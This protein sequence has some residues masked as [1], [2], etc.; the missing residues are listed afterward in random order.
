M[1]IESDSVLDLSPEAKKA[2]FSTRA[3][4][5]PGSGGDLHLLDIFEKSDEID[6][7]IHADYLFNIENLK[8]PRHQI[9][10][11]QE[12]NFEQLCVV[13]D[14]DMFH[15]SGE[16][17]QKFTD[18]QS[19]ERGTSKWIVFEGTRRRRLGLLHVFGEAVWVFH[20]VWAKKQCTPHAILLQDH[21][22]G[23]GWARLGGDES[24]LYQVAENTN[25]LPPFLVIGTNTIPWPGYRPIRGV[26]R[27]GQHEFERTLYGRDGSGRGTRKNPDAAQK[28]GSRA[29]DFAR[30]IGEIY[31][32]G[33]GRKS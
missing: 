8:L 23:A 14:A 2:L 15:P 12:L 33:A 3:A 30:I 5:Y 10:F 31:S 13:L 21:G 26:G 11:E 16:R 20:H 9:V 28:T 18:W 24:P 4:F 17:W 29:D 7:F 27:G 22:F 6:V 32:G 25:T 1:P 19:I